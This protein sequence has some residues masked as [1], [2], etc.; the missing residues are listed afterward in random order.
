MLRQDGIRGHRN[1]CCGSDRAVRWR[2][3][4]CSRRARGGGPG[5]ALSAHPALDGGS[6]NF[7]TEGYPEVPVRVLRALCGALL[8]GARLHAFLLRGKPKSRGG[9]SHRARRRQHEAT[10][11]GAPTRA[12]SGRAAGS[13]PG[14][15]PTRDPREIPAG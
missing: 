13:G 8:R 6:G 3:G 5:T 1:R 15:F 9:E 7:P 2:V 10:K 4:V 11:P 12:G 14:R